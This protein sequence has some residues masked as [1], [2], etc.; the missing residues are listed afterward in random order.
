MIRAARWW[1]TRG[2]VKVAKLPDNVVGRVKDAGMA[3]SSLL[4]S[5][6]SFGEAPFTGHPFGPLESAKLIGCKLMRVLLL[7]FTLF[8]LVICVV[9]SRWFGLVRATSVAESVNLAD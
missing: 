4:D 6:G 9:C 5:L 1:P 8:N 2:W 3:V 7:I